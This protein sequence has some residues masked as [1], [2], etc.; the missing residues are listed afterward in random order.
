MLSNNDILSK[1]IMF[2]RFPLIVAVV[3]I[4]TNL[5]DIMINGTLLVNEGQFPIHDLFRHVMTNELARIAVPLFFFI[6]GFLFF[7]RS[8]FSLAVY[9]MKLKKRIR[10]LLI[11]YL[12]WNIIV[13]LLL[14]L[15]QLFLSSTTSGRNKLISDYS[16]LDWLNLFWEHREGMPICYQF[17]FIRD[18]IFVILCSPAVYYFIRYGKIFSLIILGV[19]WTFGLWFK[20]PGISITAFF[21]FSFGAWFSI[22]KR[23]F[24]IDFKPIL[25]P[26]TILYMMLLVA[27]T[28]L[29]YNKVTGY[30]FLY[31]IGIVVGLV[32]IVAWT[33]YGI[34]KKR[35]CVSAFLAGSAFF[36]YAYHGMPIALITKYWVK[37]FQPASEIT[38]L[39]GYFLIPLFIVGVGIGVYAGLRK[40]FPA[41]TGLITGRGVNEISRFIS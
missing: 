32:A 39:A 13:F 17:W 36:V 27:G 9:G 16:W 25:W 5:T 40:Y 4:H 20:V 18:L 33:A 28:L 29:W 41:F 37:L 11:P 19:L 15:T 3:F 10:T 30:S 38:M 22:N 23:N 2:L 1:T 8:D 21:F 7:Y 35:L 34:A 6:S 14:L 12:F 24:T 26:A 31:N